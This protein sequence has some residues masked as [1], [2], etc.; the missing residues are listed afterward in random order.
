MHPT[1]HTWQSRDVLPFALSVQRGGYIVAPL[2][3]GCLKEK[4]KEQRT[5]LVTKLGNF[6][7]PP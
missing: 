2:K 6:N 5:E 1:C 3:W 7:I 4:N